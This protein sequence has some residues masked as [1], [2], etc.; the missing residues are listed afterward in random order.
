MRRG[1]VLFALAILFI[2]SAI[3]LAAAAQAAGQSTP[4]GIATDPILQPPFEDGK[5][6]DMMVGLHIV[7][8]AAI[9]EVNEQFQLDA[10]LFAR[11]M[12]KRLAYTSEGPQDEVR[13]YATGQIWIPQLEMINAATPR[14]RDETSITVS[15]DGMVTYAERAVVK[16]SSRFELRRFPFDQ[17][18]LVVIIHPFLAYGPQIKF[19]LNDEST[20]TASEFRT[21]SSL[22][23]WY[24]TGLHSEVITAPTYG[25]MTVPEA[26]FE[27]DVS[28]RS[29]F[30][31]WKVFLPLLLMVFLSWAVF[32]IEAHDLSNQVQVAVTTILTVIA[33][34]FAISATMPRLPYLTYIDAFFLECYIFVFLAVVELMTVHVAHRS[35]LR[36]DLGLRIRKYSR[37]VIPSAFVV[38]NVLIAHHFLG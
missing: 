11:W 23:Q 32:W 24:L 34:A 13:N 29:S 19:K 30:Y 5:P 20:W 27:I 16:L 14:S 4:T 37:W 2:V 28:R 35:E 25:G 7:N 9:D 18:R 17:Q 15:P 36:R 22:A 3:L 38:T 10:Y 26:R 33:F 8:L 1:R 31:L 21:Y 12:D 6:I